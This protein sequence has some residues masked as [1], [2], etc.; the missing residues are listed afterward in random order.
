[1]CHETIRNG[2][3]I[4]FRMKKRKEHPNWTTNNGFM[5]EQNVL[6]LR[7]EV[8]LLHRCREAEV[9]IMLNDTNL[10]VARLQILHKLS[11]CW[12][13]IHNYFNMYASWAKHI[14]CQQARNRIINW[15]GD[16]FIKI[17]GAT[18]CFLFQL[19]Q[20]QHAIIQWHEESF[21]HIY[22]KI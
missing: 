22:P 15:V 6:W 11:L 19:K 4:R 3:L 20:F 2:F 1:M 12:N 5:A 14:S 17:V 10:P 8:S 9:L 16:L 7:D 21:F 18:R 13:F